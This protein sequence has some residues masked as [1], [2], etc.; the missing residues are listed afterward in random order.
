METTET[1]IKAIMLNML[2][3]FKNKPFRTRTPWIFYNW[4]V[5]LNKKVSQQFQHSCREK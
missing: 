5:H 4:K 3:D 1:D 2:R